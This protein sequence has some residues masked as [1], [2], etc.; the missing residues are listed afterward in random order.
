MKRAFPKLFVT[1]LDGTALGGGHQP[2][3]RFPD[4][5]SRF[6]DRLASRGCQWA[7]STTWDVGGQWQLVASS[8]V[9]SRPVLLMGEIGLRLARWGAEGPVMV[10]PYTKRMEARLY[11]T[12]ESS[13][14]PV[15]RQVCGRIRAQRALFYGHWFDFWPVKAERP[16]VRQL[17]RTLARRAA[18]L[19]VSCAEDGSFFHAHPAW[20]G[21]GLSLKASLGLLKLTPDDVVVAGDH[22]PDLNMMAPELARHLIAPGSAEASVRAHVAAHGGAVGRSG[23]GQGVVEAFDA[24]ARQRGWDW[25]GEGGSGRARR[26]EPRRTASPR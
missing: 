24:L 5:F 10:Q 25:A 1:D 21:K 19:S 15:I 9:Q 14:R 18:D 12:C 11:R 16:A 20:L 17:G 13:L 7:I 8:A 3:A 26:S 23:Y 2:Y 6:L 4:P 22:T